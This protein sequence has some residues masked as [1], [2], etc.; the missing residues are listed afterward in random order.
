MKKLTDL[1]TLLM[2]GLLLFF[3]IIIAVYNI[4]T[5]AHADGMDES[6]QRQGGAWVLTPHD[7]NYWRDFDKHPCKYNL[8]YNE[9]ECVE[10]PDRYS[11]NKSENSR[12]IPPVSIPEPEI[13]GLLGVGVS[14]FV[15]FKTW[16]Q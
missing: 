2:L 7:V 3:G 10:K 14:V 4:S 1:I 8:G 12:K 15:A 9:N 11:W 16:R 6:Y 5:P 13:L